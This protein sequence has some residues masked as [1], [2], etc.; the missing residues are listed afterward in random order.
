MRAFKTFS[1][2][3]ESNAYIQ[4]PFSSHS[5]GTTGNQYT[6]GSDDPEVATASTVVTAVVVD[7]GSASLDP[8][9]FLHT[10]NPND[11][12]DK[13]GGRRYNQNWD[14]WDKGDE[15]GGD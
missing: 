14:N 9:D 5:S 2:V 13:L 12:V 15:Y 8:N 7:G 6:R 10:N 4:R 1:S 11:W 3:A